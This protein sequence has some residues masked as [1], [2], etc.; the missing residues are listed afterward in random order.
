MRTIVLASTSPYRQQQLRQLRIPFVAHP[1]SASESL[2][3]NQAIPIADKVAWLS[4]A[5]AESLA[6]LFPQA[7]M[8]GGDQI[9]T[10]DD[11][12]LEKP[13]SR[14]KAC[15]QLRRLLGRSHVLWSGVAIHDPVSARTE[16]AI[17][18][19]TLTMRELSEDRMIA[20]LDREQP[21]DCVGSY[22]IESEGIC[23]FSSIQGRDHSAIMGLPLLQLVQLLERFDIHLP[24]K[25]SEL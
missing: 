18:S 15:L 25:H 9:V 11:E 19:L 7:L 3:K 6:P 17:E 2:V 16:W 4:K 22:K 20:Y 1:H 24:F 21:W 13:G 12:V 5:K 10:V 14:E 8:I 23:L